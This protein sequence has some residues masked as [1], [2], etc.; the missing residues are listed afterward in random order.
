[1]DEAAVGN[2]RTTDTDDSAE[3]IAA[4]REHRKPVVRGR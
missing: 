4:F 2:P 3:E 1:M